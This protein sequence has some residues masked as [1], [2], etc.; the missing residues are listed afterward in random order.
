MLKILERLFRIEVG[1]REPDTTD[2]H[3]SQAQLRRQRSG[4]QYG[5]DIVVRFKGTAIGASS[6][7]LVECKN[8]A[9]TASALTVGNRGGQGPPGRG[10]LRR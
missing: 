6:T 9:S 10:Q 1:D 8:Y 4:T 7:C 5:A 2:S 3:R